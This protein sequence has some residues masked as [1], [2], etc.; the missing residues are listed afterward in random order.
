MAVALAF[1]LMFLVTETESFN[2]QRALTL[3]KR[4]S[5]CFGQLGCFSTDPPFSSADR[6]LTLLPESPDDILTKLDLYSKDGPTTAQELDAR[7]PE[8]VS[9]V[10]TH[11]GHRPTQFIVH[12]FLND[13][14]TNDWLKN[15]KDELLKA[16]D[17][18]VIIVNWSAGN[19]PPY[20]RASANTRV[21]GAQ[22]ALVIQELIKSKGVSAGDFHII[23]HSLG[24]HV[25]G[26]AGERVPGLGRITGLDPAGPEFDNTDITVRLDPTD[27]VF[28]DVIHTDANDLLHLGFGTK[29]ES[30][31]ADF[32]PNLGHDQP[33]CT[34]SPIV[35]IAEYGFL[36][37]L[38]E[39]VACNH[40]RSIKFFTE[41]INTQCPF[42]AY[43][44][45]SD[46]QFENNQC[47]TCPAGGCPSMGFKASQHKPTGGSQ[48]KYY[49]TT[50]AHAP[51]CEYHLDLSVKF[52]AGQGREERGS[53]Q[54]GVQ[55]DKGNTGQIS[56]VDGDGP[57][58]I[59]PGTTYNFNLGTPTDIGNIQSLSFTWDHDSSLLSP[60][61]WNILG[62][63]H[64]TLYVD[65]VTVTN[66]ESK[67]N[68]RF[69]AAGS[70]VET[71]HTL[72]I[73]TKC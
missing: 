38:K 43:P 49:L 45:D 46:G 47:Q 60:S 21:V 56:V 8:T 15:M 24:A 18:N 4:D 17:Y 35:Q 61:D 31:S 5:V 40:L 53:I 70:G 27:A 62:L 58:Q 72:A 6:T 64:P 1:A 11:F 52:S 19:K 3:D 28:V 63:R 23:G 33:G 55:G 41:S 32:Y 9:S 73:A 10:W 68:A 30:G 7:H 44:C 59:A 34:R 66:Q 67:S 50:A 51:F 20:T 26:Y 12:G 69:C 25:A 29:T 57:I 37:G 71:D 14:N 48:V 65:E 16:G 22:L 39:V 42:V 2:P 13:P 36:Q 54:V